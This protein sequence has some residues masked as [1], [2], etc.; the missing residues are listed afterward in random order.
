MLGALLGDFADRAKTPVEN[1]AD[2][3]S[4]ALVVGRLPMAHFVSRADTEDICFASRL[5]RDL[6]MITAGTVA[7]GNDAESYCGPVPHEIALTADAYR[8]LGGWR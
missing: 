8:M 4:R 5:D 6:Q 1:A 3:G 2:A 7:V